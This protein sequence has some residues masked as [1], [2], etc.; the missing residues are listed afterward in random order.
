MANEREMNNTVPL[1]DDLVEELERLLHESRRW[2]LLR[3][4]CE[5]R[6][7]GKATPATWLRLRSARA[8]LGD[9]HGADEALQGSIHAL[10]TDFRVPW[11]QAIS[12]H[13]D[14]RGRA[15]LL[16]AKRAYALRIDASRI[17]NTTWVRFGEALSA[18]DDSYVLRHVLE[19][20][21]LDPALP[22]RLAKLLVARKRWNQFLQLRAHQLMRARGQQIAGARI[23]LARALDL[24]DRATSAELVYPYVASDAESRGWLSRWLS[25]AGRWEELLT[26]RALELAEEVTSVPSRVRLLG[27]L[28]RVDER[29][30]LS[31]VLGPLLESIEALAWLEVALGRFE[32]WLQRAQVLRALVNLEPEVFRHR[33]RWLEALYRAGESAQ[34]REVL[35]GALRANT[36]YA[37]LSE[38]ARLARASGDLPGLS[39]IRC[40]QMQLRP[41]KLELAD[42]HVRLLRTA[43]AEADAEAFLKDLARLDVHSAEQARVLRRLLAREGRWQDLKEMIVRAREH[44]PG[45]VD[46][47]LELSAVHQATGEAEMAREIVGQV[48]AALDSDQ[49]ESAPMSADIEPVQ[50]RVKALRV[51]PGAW[52]AKLE[53][54][55]LSIVPTKFAPLIEHLAAR[56]QDHGLLEI[57]SGYG[58]A[59]VKVET[60]L[61]APNEIR[62]GRRVGEFLSWVVRDRRPGM[63]VEVGTG[64]GVSGMYWAA[65]F[66]EAGNGD[67]ITFEPNEAWQHIAEGN[68]A[69]ISRRARSVLGTFETGHSALTPNSVDMIFID[70][71]HT[72]EA[73]CGQ[74]NLAVPLLRRPSL[75]VIDDIHFSEEMYRCWRELALG[76]K[77]SAAVEIEDRLGLLEIS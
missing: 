37:V 73:V 29:A 6:V 55:L 71:I 43:G 2:D 38:L 58:A 34:C 25:Q 57:W 23:R 61:R 60:R 5:S 69:V 65:G 22:G 47:M 59:D 36:S 16:L 50:I 8:A 9:L 35:E 64:F 33:L 26:L 63:A 10:T 3:A 1:A 39:R 74:V 28:R 48:R 20:L 41:E 52:A 19:G 66:E 7:A 49:T 14:E 30:E 76:P 27:A 42:Q 17:S 72:P 77:V 62:V 51:E 13:V 44:A 12:R 11:F 18:V 54:G 24:A 4:V 32:R 40:A 53:T 45:R 56:T 15:R 75:M 46:L 70:A 21:S 67:F 68:L 31:S